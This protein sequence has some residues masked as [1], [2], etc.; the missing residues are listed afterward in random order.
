MIGPERGTE[1]VSCQS[2]SGS[3]FTS[4]GGFSNLYQMPT[5]QKE[6]HTQYFEKIGLNLPYVNIT[7]E[8]PQGVGRSRNNLFPFPR[9]NLKGRGYPDV[10]LL[11]GIL[12][13]KF[14]VIFYCFFF[15]LE[16]ILIN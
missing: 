14:H 11:G 13:L 6:S 8:Y 2:N 16:L 9:Y 3:A 12:D 7:R 5:W 4:G 1:E 10:T 15:F